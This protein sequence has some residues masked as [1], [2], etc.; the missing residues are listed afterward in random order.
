MPALQYLH[1]M[2]CWSTPGW[3]QILDGVFVVKLSDYTPSLRRSL[4]L[5]GVAAAG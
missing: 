5:S 3:V 4:S 2:P 1:E